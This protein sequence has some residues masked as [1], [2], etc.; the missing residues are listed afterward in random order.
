MYKHMKDCLWQPTRLRKILSSSKDCSF[1]R[2][3][4]MAVSYL[5]LPNCKKTIRFYISSQWLINNKI[6]LP[7]INR[8]RYLSNKSTRKVQFRTGHCLWNLYLSSLM[9]LTSCSFSVIAN[10]YN[11]L[12]VCYQIIPLQKNTTIPSL[13]LMYFFS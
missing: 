8:Q 12:I 13:C 6:A 3:G 10:D 2:A 11:Q 5:F 9:Q 4:R 7:Q 1:T